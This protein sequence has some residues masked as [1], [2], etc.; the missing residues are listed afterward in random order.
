LYNPIVIFIRIRISRISDILRLDSD[1]LPTF[2]IYI[3]VKDSYNNLKEKKND[4]LNSV[5]ES[6]GKDIMKYLKSI[7]NDKINSMEGN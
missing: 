3:L 5:G 4:F 7:L 1:Y 2:Y 6:I